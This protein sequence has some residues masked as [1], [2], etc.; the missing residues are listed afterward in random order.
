MLRDAVATGSQTASPDDQIIAGHAFVQDMRRG[1]FNITTNL[2]NLR[3]AAAFGDLFRSDDEPG[4]RRR[5]SRPPIPRYNTAPGERGAY[6]VAEIGGCVGMRRR[7]QLLGG[8]L[9]PLMMRTVTME[10][11]SG[12]VSPWRAGCSWNR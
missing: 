7:D 6:E 12:L 3:L 11:A 10:G 2:A 8:G 1:R 5:R 4:Y 9:L